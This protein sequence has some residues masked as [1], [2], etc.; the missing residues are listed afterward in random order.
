MRTA[1]A[2]EAQGMWKLKRWAPDLDSVS[3]ASRGDELQLG[4][5]GQEGLRGG[6]GDGDEGNGVYRVLSPERALPI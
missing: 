1:P 3:K 4:V 6:R 2:R 5:Q